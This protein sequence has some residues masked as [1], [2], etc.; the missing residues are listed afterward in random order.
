MLVLSGVLIVIRGFALRLNPLVVVAV[1]GVVTGIAGVGKV[2]GRLV[3]DAIP[4]TSRSIAVMTYTLGMAL[5][6]VIMGNSFAAFP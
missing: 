6:T 5:F 2:I 4:M 1:A 3:T